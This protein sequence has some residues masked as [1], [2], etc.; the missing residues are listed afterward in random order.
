MSDLTE[1]LRRDAFSWRESMVRKP[2]RYHLRKT[3]ELLDEAVA[4]IEELEA[5]ILGYRPLDTTDPMAFG[6]SML[7][8][9]ATGEGIPDIPKLYWRE[10]E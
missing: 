10:D 8:D 4:R 2:A 6:P 9:A 7:R 1:R 5:H 3:C